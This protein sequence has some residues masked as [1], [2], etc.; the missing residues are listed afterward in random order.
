MKI[1][2]ISDSHGNKSGLENIILKHQDADLFLH[3]GDG[4]EEFFKIKSKYPNLIMEIVRGNCDF[5]YG[6]LPDEKTFSAGSHKILASH[7]YKYN[8]KSGLDDYI[9]AARKKS[10]DII[11]YGHTHKRLTK[12]E[13]GLYIMNPGSL[14]RPRIGG[15]SYG[16]INVDNN[17]IDM[18]IIEYVD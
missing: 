2:V 9:Q 12:I 10:A 5:G 15:P 14:S 3:L 17:Q 8:V 11:L 7:G 1:V 13:N 16:I 18:N 6:F 4:A